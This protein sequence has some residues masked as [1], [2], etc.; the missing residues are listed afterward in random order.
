MK[1]P[2]AELDQFSEFHSKQNRTIDHMNGKKTPKC[3]RRMW[4]HFWNAQE[5]WSQ[6]E[7]VSLV[8]KIQNLRSRAFVFSIKTT[9]LTK[10]HK[11]YFPLIGTLILAGMKGISS[12][13]DIS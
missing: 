3:S 7:A 10:V 12:C 11:T 5:I 8:F 4:Q 6:S 2:A 9:E 1:R 13:G